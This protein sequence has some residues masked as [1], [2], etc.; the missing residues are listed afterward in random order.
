MLLV[1][2]LRE[3]SAADLNGTENL[4][5]DLISRL[6][7]LGKLLNILHCRNGFSVYR[8]NNIVYL[9]LALCNGSLR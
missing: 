6:H 2:G 8:S 1:R 4:Y 5:G 3:I 9:K 7:S